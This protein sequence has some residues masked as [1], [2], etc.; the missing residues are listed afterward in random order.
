MKM[1]P[2][3][4][5][6]FMLL[7]S[8][9]PAYTYEIHS[10]YTAGLILKDDESLWMTGGGVGGIDLYAHSSAKIEGTSDLIQGS[11]G[12]WEL[13]LA[14]YSTLNFIGGE[15]H[16]FSITSYATVNLIG[17]RIDYLR[18]SQGVG[19]PH[20]DLYCRSWDYNSTTKILTGIWNTDNDEDGLW[21][22]FN[23]QLIDIQGYI[24]TFKNINFIVI[25]EPATLT[26]VGL[27]GLL[28]RHK[29]T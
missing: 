20:I 13:R 7:P 21:D 14:G 23:I 29:R 28:L 5:I 1:L 16:Q 25:P 15:L 27:G 3:V 24:P 18:S 22:A 17:G 4:A 19:Y 26:L 8:I 11:G 10:G 2:V 12:I 6:M 9:S